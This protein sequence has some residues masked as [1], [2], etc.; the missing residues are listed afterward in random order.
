[1]SFL[2]R[3]A[4]GEVTAAAG[5]IGAEAGAAI[6]AMTA[7]AVGGQPVAAY[8]ETE[9]LSWSVVA[10][11]GWDLLGAAESDGGAGAGLRDLAEVAKAWGEAIVPLPLIPTMMAKRWSATAR[12]ASGPVTVAVATR[13][14]GRGVAPF[15]GWAGVTLL[16][17]QRIEDAIADD[18]APSL[19]LAETALV[20]PLDAG[21]KAELT[22][23]WAAEAVGCATRTLRDAV[24][25]ARERQQFGKPIG[26]FQAIKHHLAN[27]LIHTEQAESAVIWASLEPQ[28]AA[29]AAQVAFASSARAVEI[30]I[31]VHGGLGFTWEMGVHF[32][33]R[34]VDALGELCRELNR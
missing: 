9:P 28:H 30:A 14:A 3:G 26:S 5:E 27:A 29:R 33:L 8:V 20:T 17:G 13:G 2:D 31:Q 25:Y 15:G 34:H 4:A 32:Y 1:M 6:R 21:Q 10:E 18:Y 7:R 19:R 12:E 24:G 22:V 16:G 23:V 11:G